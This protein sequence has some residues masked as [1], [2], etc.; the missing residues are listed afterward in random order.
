M[1]KTPLRVPLRAGG[2][3]AGTPCFGCGGP[4][5]MGTLAVLEPCDVIPLPA[6]YQ[7]SQG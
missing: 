5:W 6:R 7:S 2:H 1:Q 4:I 3:C